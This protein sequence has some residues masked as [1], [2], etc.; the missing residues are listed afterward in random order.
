MEQLIRDL[1]DPTNQAFP[2]RI[3]Q[4]QTQ[5]QQLQRERSA[6]D[7][8]LAF[9]Q[10]DDAIIRFY[11]A[12]TLTIKI[13]VDWDNDDLKG[14]QSMQEH[15]RHALVAS[16]VRLTLLEDAAFVLQKLCSTLCTLYQRTAENWNNPIR[17]VFTCLIHGQYLAQ[18]EALN[19]RDL[20]G[21]ETDV[22]PAR[23]SSALR[24]TSTLAEDILSRPST[25]SA[26]ARSL[27]RS[28]GDAF[29]LFTLCLRD[30]ELVAEYQLS[31]AASTTDVSTSGGRLALTQLTLQTLPGWIPLIRKQT[32]QVPK[33]EAASTSEEAL[34]SI[35]I[36]LRCLEDE[37]L[38][39]AALQAIIT[40]QESSSAL[41]AKASSDF[42]ESV[43][44][45]RP[46]QQYHSQLLAGDF[47]P[48]AALLAD[49]LEAVIAQLDTTSPHYIETGRYNN[50]LQML[51]DLLRCPGVPAVEDDV[52]P[53]VLDSIAQILEG[54][55]DWNE[56]SPAEDFLKDYARQACQSCLTKLVIPDEELSR[57]TE[58][59][60]RD[61][62][63]R[64]H[65]F[66]R[67]VQD[68]FQSAFGLLGSSLVEAVVIAIAQ[69]SSSTTWGEFDAALTCLMAFGD[70]MAAEPETY[71]PYIAAVLSSQNFQ[72]VLNG[73]TVPDHPRSTSIKFLAGCTT[74][75]QAHPNL[76][77]ILNFLFSSLHLPASA[78]GASRAIYA[79]C[80]A[81]RTSLT[82]AM[83]SFLTSFNTIVDLQAVERQRIFGGVAA[84]VQALP[85]ESDKIGPLD[86]MLTCISGDTSQV[87]GLAG[88]QETQVQCTDNTLGTLA[89]IGRGLRAPE[90]APHVM[91]TQPRLESSFWT[92]G[93]GSGIQRQVLKIYETTMRQV[94]LQRDVTTIEVAC[95][96]LRSGVPEKHPSP[97]KFTLS[98][99]IDLVLRM[100]TLDS[101][102]INPVLE[103]ASALLAANFR[104]THDQ[105]LARI[106]E[107]VHNALQQLLQKSDSSHA[108]RSS[109]FPAASLDF[110]S[111]L[112]PR[113]ATTVLGSAEGLSVFN[114]FI[115]TALA[116]ISYPD[117]LPR[118]SAAT[119]FSVLVD[120]S[121]PGKLPIDTAE[122]VLQVILRERSPHIVACLIRLLGGECARS[123][124]EALTDPIKRYVQYQPMLFKNIA[125]EAMKE[126]SG[127]LNAKALS[128]TTIEHRLRVVAQLDTLRGARKT[129]DVVKDFWL[130]CRGAS[131]EYIA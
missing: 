50:I 122:S 80:D 108:A 100:I 128:S 89:A 129:N 35:A 3:K 51:L 7:I 1:N 60:D 118:R 109:D 75:L 28:C 16:Y 114:T 101:A 85:D 26:V 127:V 79:L 5:L 83:P 105:H 53:G 67:D 55:T 57:A 22:A 30:Q 52:C 94:N 97:F 124:L 63:T 36:A 126:T 45:T 20:A 2:E 38:T 41:L 46:V 61:D 47:N 106:L 98:T 4:I 18:D 95:Q 123:E 65:V 49:F 8:G 78:G 110:A 76:M 90:D 81:Q 29:A 32:E 17:H 48:S 10:H 43:I 86:T 21:P 131:F 56:P 40:I 62:R 130:A 31:N 12:L 11:G 93:P 111:R 92:D 15:L 24:L 72:S 19:I 99:T 96:F 33:E 66:V 125:K 44:R 116:V 59:W 13:N 42:P 71:N 121:K 54:H 58:T 69:P 103:C 14:D 37:V 23:L 74:Y 6:W 112:L 9:L 70:T 120:I 68:F 104:E 113:W 119:F 84:I 73:D 117:T 107:A 82:Q 91:E 34:T 87:S 102:N 77:Q 88:D 64:F 27:S 115:D 39:D 25:D